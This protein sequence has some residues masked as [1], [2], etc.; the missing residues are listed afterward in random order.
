[1]PTIPVRNV[2]ELTWPSPV[3]R[4]LSTKRSSPAAKPAWSGC[5]TIDG[6]NSAEASKLYS[7]MK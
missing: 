2:T 7:W 3:A 1:M 6:L 5:A 4:R